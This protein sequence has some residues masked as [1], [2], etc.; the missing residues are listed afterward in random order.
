VHIPARYYKRI[1]K[2]YFIIGIL[3]V[4]SSFNM[5][6]NPL[7]SY[8]Y[9]MAGVVS[10][11]YALSVA[12]ARRKRRR[13][14]PPELLQPAPDE[15][16]PTEENL[17]P[18]V[19]KRPEFINDNPAATDKEQP[20]ADQNTATANEEQA[21]PEQKES[22]ADSQEKESGTEN[23]DLPQHGGGVASP[24]QPELKT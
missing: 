19:N 1:P 9:F 16:A 5:D 6:E 13:S 23:R 15:E 24:A 12:Q 17:P 14:V 10:V 22:V 3:L 7:G 4:I 18:P 2:F 11:V 20:P 8:L 21:P